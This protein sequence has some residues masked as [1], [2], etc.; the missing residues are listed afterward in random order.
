MRRLRRLAEA[1]ALR[2]VTRA[3]AGAVGRARVAGRIAPLLESA[4]AAVGSPLNG[5]VVEIADG[6]ARGL[7]IVGERRSLA[8]LSGRVEPEV[9]SVLERELIPGGVFVDAGASVGFFT[10][11]AA[12]IVG[13][14][15]RVVAF[16]PQPAAA[17]AIRANADL[18]SFSQVLV[19]EAALSDGGGT[20]VLEGLGTATAHVATRAG[21]RRGLQVDRVSLDGF[22]EAHADLAPDLVKIDVEG[23]EAS[24]LGGMAATLAEH[25]PTL[26]IELHGS[27]HP[28]V[29]LLE[30]TGYAVSVVGSTSTAREA[31]PSA[32]LFAR[33]PVAD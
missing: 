20:A 32:H 5:R 2:I 22:L 30:A 1:V 11:L 18:N 24:V 10:L 6:P 4:F 7:R 28:I 29:E 12:R 25:G 21:S 3:P 23:H 26:V 31:A 13:S 15:G 33:R 27:P 8:W 19:V 16:E 14:G 9:Q 17:A